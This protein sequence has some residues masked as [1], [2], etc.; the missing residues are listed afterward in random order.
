M[1]KYRVLLANEDVHLVS[2]LFLA[3]FF[4]FRTLGLLRGGVSGNGSGGG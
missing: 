1:L 3:F 4:C 2:D